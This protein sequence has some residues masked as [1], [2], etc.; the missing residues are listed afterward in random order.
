MQVVFLL[1][2]HTHEI[3]SV[4]SSL[5]GG[6]DVSWNQLAKEG[7]RDEYY[8][9]SRRGLQEAQRAVIWH[10]LGKVSDVQVSV[11]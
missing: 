5:N 7:R 1:I 4:S 8:H 10:S 3:Y 2:A 11:W 6:L 9:Q